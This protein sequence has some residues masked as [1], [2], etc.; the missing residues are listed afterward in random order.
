MTT[1]RTRNRSA[2]LFAVAAL[3]AAFGMS[4]A[5]NAHAA[6]PSPADIATDSRREPSGIIAILIG[7]VAPPST[8]FMDYTD[9]ACM[10]VSDGSSNTIMFGA[11]ACAAMDEAWNAYL[12]TRPVGFAIDVGTSE[13][14]FLHAFDGSTFRLLDRKTLS[15]AMISGWLLAAGP[16]STSCLK[17]N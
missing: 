8:G 13:E 17:G 5:A 16:G 9:D 4:A 12:E 15:N 11:C 7:A 14:L 2:S 1:P 6:D 3:L 10:V